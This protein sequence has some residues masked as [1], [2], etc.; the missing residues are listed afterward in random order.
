MFSLI[1]LFLVILFLSPLSLLLTTR[2]LRVQEATI[3][4]CVVTSFVLGVI[5]VAYSKIAQ[6]AGIAQHELLDGLVTIVL[7]VLI[8]GWQLQ[9]GYIR[10]IGV[11][12]LW[13]VLSVASCLLLAL[14]LGLSMPDWATAMAGNIEAAS[15]ETDQSAVSMPQDGTNHSIL[16]DD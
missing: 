2:I 9:I 15:S 6:V 4:K 10:S 7:G 11:C 3:S 13:G 1:I 12:L 8:L 16:T 5:M 14:T